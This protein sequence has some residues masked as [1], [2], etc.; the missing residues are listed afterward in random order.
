MN[1]DWDRDFNVSDS[2]FGWNQAHE[3]PESGVP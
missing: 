1:S 2:S 3:F